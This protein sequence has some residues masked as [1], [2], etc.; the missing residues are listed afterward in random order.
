[1][2]TFGKYCRSTCTCNVE[3][4]ASC[5]HVNGTCTCKTG[6]QGANCT[7]DVNECDDN[8]CP[9]NTTCKNT[10]GSYQCSCDAGFKQD[11]DNCTG[12]FV[13][14][15]AQRLLCIKS[16]LGEGRT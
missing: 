1:M 10:E 7:V 9:Q 15:A 11:G 4:T 2:G 12:T 13:K 5:D 14:Y 6:W 3:N 8:V 16:L